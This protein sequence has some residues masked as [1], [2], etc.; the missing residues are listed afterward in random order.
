MP[1][2]YT[3]AQIIGQAN[4]ITENR[5]VNLVGVNL[6]MEFWAFLD[7]F[8]QKRKYWWRQC[9]GQFSTVI[10]TQSYDLSQATDQAG[11]KTGDVMEVEAL[12]IMNPANENCWPGMADP[13]FDFKTMTAGLFDPNVSLL[14]LRRGK[15][16]MIPKY[17]QKLYF[18]EIPQSV[19]QIGFMYWAVPMVNDFTG[20][21]LNTV[22]PLVP[23][24][25]HYGL[26]FGFARRIFAI[27][28]GQDDPRFTTYDKLY[29]E[30]IEDAAANST[31]FSSQHAVSCGTNMPGVHSSGIYRG[32]R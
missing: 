5:A 24:H 26:I 17:F 11:N 7:E 32:R 23:P 12:F 9:A 16:F 29:E 28:Y 22:V 13:S 15:W 21:N 3:P 20:D 4:G 1:A 25:L 2:G 30:F 8:C 31:S 27:L 18:T 19:L 10:G 14:P 6:N